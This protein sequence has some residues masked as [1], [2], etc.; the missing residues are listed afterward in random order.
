MTAVTLALGSNLGDRHQNLRRALGEL[1]AAG[2]HVSRASSI[3]ETDPVPADQ[4][5]YLN[6]VVVADCD[7][8]PLPLLRELKRIEREMGRQEGRRWGPRPIDLDILF[9][10]EVQLETEAL[11]IPHPRIAERSFVLAPLTEVSDGPLPVL[12]RNAA[13]L[14][15]AVGTT[16]VERTALGLRPG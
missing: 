16:G 5:R 11:T 4:P 10:D 13:D 12:G 8:E 6:A 3:W 14:L 2:V 9:Y 7:L 1:E 15:A